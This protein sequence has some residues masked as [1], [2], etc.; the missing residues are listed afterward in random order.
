MPAAATILQYLHQTGS[1]A[2]REAR[3]TPFYLAKGITLFE[4][5]K[6]NPQQR[7][8]FDSFMRFRRKEILP[9]YEVFPVTDQLSA[10]LRSDPRATLL[11]DVGGSR[12]HDLLKFKEQHSSL[13]GRLILQEL[14]ETINSLSD[15]LGGIEAMAYNFYDPQPV[16][17]A[18]NRYWSTTAASWSLI[19]LP[20]C[21]SILLWR[22]LS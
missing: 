7:T 12:G 17:G 18:S 8:V 21:S 3:E 13:S 14:P 22:D 9:W 6:E 11:V 19:V 2:P 15:E 5:L 1:R 4:W 10:G 20:R 16:I